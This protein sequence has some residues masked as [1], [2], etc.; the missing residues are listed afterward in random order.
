MSVEIRPR[1]E[2][3]AAKPRDTTRV[4]GKSRTEFY[5]HHTTG[6]TLGA[7]ET[8]EWLRSIQAYH[9]GVKGWSDI[10]YNFL[11]DAEGVAWEGRGWDVQGAHCTG[12]NTS[13]IG[14]AYLGNGAEDVPLVALTT[15]AELL[16]DAEARFDRSLIVRGHRDS[17]STA[18]PGD[19]L[20]GHLSMLREP[21]ASAPPVAPVPQAPLTAPVFPLPRG[22]W[23]GPL[24]EGRRSI[25]GRTSYRGEL[26][27]WQ[28]Q[29]AERGWS[30][31]PDG[32]YGPVTAGTARLFQAEKGLTVDGR[33]G[34]LTWRAAWEAPLTY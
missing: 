9:K 24:D 5:V 12:H 26:T 34:P 31:E 30:L 4:Q 22:Y 13:G 29:M 32:I 15:I 19:E 3:R 11:V 17:A 2:W 20:Y 18:C 10:G 7:G 16:R 8:P 33:I 1:A 14:V 27:P 25:S 28:A 6:E 21:V 23:F